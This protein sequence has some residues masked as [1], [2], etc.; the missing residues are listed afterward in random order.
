MKRPHLKLLQCA[1]HHTNAG[2]M[3]FPILYF[4]VLAYRR[5]KESRVWWQWWGSNP[6]QLE[7]EVR[8]Y[9]YRGTDVWLCRSTCLDTKDQTKT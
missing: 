4:G 1:D 3:L 9:N 2:H 6:G 7:D 8:A 5:S